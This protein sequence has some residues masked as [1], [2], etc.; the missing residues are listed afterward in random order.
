MKLTK[1]MLK[2][3]KLIIHKGSTLRQLAKEMKKSVNWTSEIVSDLEREGFVAKG[4]SDRAT[5]SRITFHVAET[6]YALK[7]RDLIIK[8]RQQEQAV[9]GNVFYHFIP[10]EKNSLADSLVNIGFGKDLL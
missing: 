9:G 3:F 5:R 10:R 1:S 4:L 7:L 8:V 2:I 6:E